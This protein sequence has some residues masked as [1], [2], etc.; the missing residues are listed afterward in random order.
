VCILALISSE[1]GAV[2]DKK[3]NGACENL[4]PTMVRNSCS[5]KQPPRLE[6]NTKGSEAVM[7]EELPSDTSFGTKRSAD[8]SAS[9]ESKKVCISSD[10]IDFRARSDWVSSLTESEQDTVKMLLDGQ[11]ELLPSSNFLPVSA[12]SNASLQRALELHQRCANVQWLK[13][14]ELRAELKAMNMDPSGFKQDLKERLTKKFID[15]ASA[16]EAAEAA[17]AAESALVAADS[18][19]SKTMDPRSYYSSQPVAQLKRLLTDR[20]LKPKG[21]KADIVALLVSND[22][23]QAASSSG[24]CEVAEAVVSSTSSKYF[25]SVPHEAVAKA[26]AQCVPVDLTTSSVVQPS[27]TSPLQ[28]LGSSTA[29]AARRAG[30]GPTLI[31]TPM[32]ILDQWQHEITTHCV[33][34]LFKVCVY[35]GNTRDA[36]DM[37]GADIVLSTYGVV[38]SDY[39]KLGPLFKMNWHR[40]VLDEAHNIRSRLTLMAKSCFALNSKMRWAVTGTPVQNRLG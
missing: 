26:S 16:V 35:Y 11:S 20:G 2:Q 7:G 29:V 36:K 40:V 34:G 22:L 33:P 38:S 6:A 21:S 4:S 3:S 17:K 23:D 30:C 10:A 28:R 8:V 15:D 24:L 5:Q 32:T 1:F 9:S 19:A 39:D 27:L 13:V 14:P 18:A 31:I 12:T 37:Q 25:V